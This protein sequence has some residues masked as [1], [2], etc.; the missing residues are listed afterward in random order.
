MQ[1]H[2]PSMCPCRVDAHPCI[3][4]SFVDASSKGINASAVRLPNTV[5][6]L[7]RMLASPWVEMIL[8]RGPVPTCSQGSCSQS[9]TDNIDLEVTG[10]G[11]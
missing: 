5:T 8:V 11:A 1:E 9:F 3:E 10:R 7:S 6:M 2:L 4:I